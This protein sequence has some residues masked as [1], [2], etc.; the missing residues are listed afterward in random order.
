MEKQDWLTIKHIF[1]QATQL[2]IEEQHK[3]VTSLKNEKETVISKVLKMLATQTSCNE[4]AYER[5]FQ[6]IIQANVDGLLNANI[7]ARVGNKIEQFTIESLIGE[8]GMGQ[9][10][11]A[12]RDTD[13]FT[14][15]VAIKFLQTHKITSDSRQ[16]LKNERKILASLQHKNIAS[17]I[18]GGETQNGQPYIVMEYV[19]GQPITEYCERK[20]LS[21]FERIQLFMQVLSAV[22]YAHQNLVIH[23]DIKPGNVLVTEDGDVK[24]LD[25]GI[26]KIVQDTEDDA[27]LTLTQTAYR[28]LSLAS[29]SPEQLSGDS[30]SVLSDVYALG[31]LLMHMITE[32]PLIG[33]QKQSIKEIEQ[34]ILHEVP[35]PPSNFNKNVSKD[36]DTIILKALQKEPDRRYGSVEQL[37]SDLHNYMN[38]YPISARPDSGWYVFSKLVSRNKAASALSAGLL[39]SLVVFVSVLVVQSNVIRTER[40]NAIAQATIARQTADTMAN[41]F[42]AAD[43]NVN[44]GEDITA[45]MLLDQAK[46]EIGNLS[47]ADEIKVEMMLSL[48]RV[49]RQLNQL[50]DAE[51]LLSDAHS[52]LQSLSTQKE[53]TQRLTVLT[54]ESQGDLFI[55]LG[56][57]DAAVQ[58]FR[59]LLSILKQSSEALFR[60]QLNE[61]KIYYDA[62][63]GLATASS[64][65]GND[66]DAATYYQK[67][68][69]QVS[70]TTL[71]PDYKA[72]ALIGLGHALRGMGDMDGSQ[73]ALREGIALERENS[74]QA[75]LVLAHG[76]NQLAS[77]LTNVNALDEALPLAQ[78]GLSIR[79][80]LLRPGHVE[81]LA[82]MGIV[83]RIF[84]AQGKLQ[85]ALD[86]KLETLLH[87]KNTLGDVHPFTALTRGVIGTLYLQLEQFD[88]AE[89]SLTKARD[90][91]KAIYSPDHVNV[92]RAAINLA[93]VYLA[94]HRQELAAQTS[95]EALEIFRESFP[96]QHHNVATATL[97]NGL[98]KGLFTPDQF[99]QKSLP[100]PFEQ[101]LIDYEVHYGPETRQH[102]A[103][104][105]YMAMLQDKK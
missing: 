97:I 38:N 11:L 102:K 66:K 6:N 31:A 48:S 89:A 100:R 17:L 3:F 12:T 4:S 95:D 34:A 76:L 86:M 90:D 88:K 22:S 37:R 73:S 85:Q 41:I 65:I 77:T 39:I 2:P 92:A 43:P 82:S 30:V 98:A 57:Y 63:Y 55:H 18:G 40:D 59:D 28:H 49:Y 24:L 94:Q 54:K 44:D 53:S 20:S 64:Y 93:R 67:A 61:T 70:G 51:N 58:E 5:D 10:F 81:T 1:D 16:K 104:V 105:S 8:G 52:L 46:N 83:A 45:K 74:S 26:A 96:K 15:H 80:N 27:G 29:A 75:T 9:V 69:D 47:A 79:Q 68:V 36:L 84:M 7:E 72:D 42:S 50:E 33:A 25:F 32:R 14:Q 56:N 99:L 71:E 19:V 13:E 21:L 87:L 35:S 103:L 91:L 78:E 60:I 101:A 62:F 23:R